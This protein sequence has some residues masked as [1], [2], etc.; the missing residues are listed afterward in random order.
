[1]LRLRTARTTHAIKEPLK[2][3]LLDFGLRVKST[4]TFTFAPCLRIRSEGVHL[5]DIAGNVALDGPSL[6]VSVPTRPFADRYMGLRNKEG[7]LD[8]AD[9]S[10]ITARYTHW[11]GSG[12][13][14]RV[15]AIAKSTTRFALDVW[16]WTTS[17][18]TPLFWTGT[19]PGVKFH[20]SNLSLVR[21]HDARYDALRLQGSYTWHLMPGDRNEATVVLIDTDG[22]M[23][24]IELLGRDYTALEFVLGCAT[25]LDLLV[26][27]DASGAAVSAIGPHLGFRRMG[28]TQT[29]APVPDRLDAEC[30]APILFE[31]IVAKLRDDEDRAYIG[32]AGYMDSFTDHLDG[33]YLKAQVALEA[34]AKS[35]V[36]PEERTFVRS[37]RA[38]RKWVSSLR[39]IVATHATDDG[40]ARALLRKLETAIF[41][42]TSSMVP[43]ALAALGASPPE[44]VIEEVKRRNIAAHE[45]VMTRKR[46]RDVDEDF[47]RVELVRSLLGAMLARSAG[48][49][50]PLPSWERD[51][52]GYRKEIDWWAGH[53]P[54]APSDAFVAGEES[55]DE[56]RS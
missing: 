25:Q 9:G 20:Q 5:E 23:P 44:R 52:L 27:V 29:Y 33:A 18:A 2:T 53:G 51:E 1:M 41:A 15:G 26:G 8:L 42:P 43:R 14:L 32:I 16:T 4:P 22:R 31:K 38:W 54:A 28:G 30:W 45:F 6:N 10:R 46:D 11:A 7:M 37:P 34:Y 19:L 21:G 50:G 55:V 49:T 3:A 24:D 12:T 35:L 40:A 47:A 56:L 39:E 36:T 13:S 48:Y 17:P